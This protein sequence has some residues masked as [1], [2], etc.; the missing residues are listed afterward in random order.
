[1]GVGAFVIVLS[2]ISSFFSSKTRSNLTSSII[3]CLKACV[4]VR[5]TQCRS[6]LLKIANSEFSVNLC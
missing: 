5:D 6:T 3:Y 2:Q 4:I 1:M